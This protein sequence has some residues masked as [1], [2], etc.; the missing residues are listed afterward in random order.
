MY[1]P[2]QEKGSENRMRS[3][4]VYYSR[5]GSTKFV[6]EMVAKELGAE[7]EELVDQ[8]SRRGILGFLRSGYE[9]TRG[10]ETKLKETTRDPSQFDLVVLGTPVWNGRPSSPIRTYLKSHDLSGKRTAIF[11]VSASSPGDETIRRTKSLIPDCEYAG[12][13]ALS[14]ALTDKEDTERKISAWCAELRSH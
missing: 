12:Q 3:L 9:S 5:T 10:V 2:S 6:A 4:V 14:D 8:K 7:T 11:C 13:L 1:A